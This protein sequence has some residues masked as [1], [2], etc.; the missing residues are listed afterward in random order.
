MASN[1]G[2]Q[3]RGQAGR[4]FQPI[5]CS[6]LSLERKELLSDEEGEVA[7]CCTYLT[8]FRTAVSERSQ[9]EATNSGTNSVRLAPP[10]CVL[11][12]DPALDV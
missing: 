1:N 8:S 7:L 5:M 2:T 12:C 9:Y 11:D 3:D 4:Y 10:P 6:S